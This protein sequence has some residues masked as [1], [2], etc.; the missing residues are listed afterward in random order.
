MD[1][2]YS[3]DVGGKDAQFLNPNQNGQDVVRMI[4]DYCSEP[5]SIQEIMEH[6]NFESR[7]SFRRKYLSG[8][9]ESGE[10]KMTLPDKQSSK[11]QKYFS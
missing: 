4:L 8:L 6:F 3:Y 7:T 11:N 2:K 10:L 9:L 5:K 1:E